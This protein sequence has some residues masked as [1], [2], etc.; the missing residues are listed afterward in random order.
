MPTPQEFITNAL[1][2]A[3]LLIGGKSDTPKAR[4]QVLVS[5]MQESDLTKRVQT[6]G[7]PAHGL[8]QFEGGPMSGIAQC[9]LHAGAQTAAVCRAR[10]VEPTRP[11]I[12]AALVTDDVLAAALAR[13]LLMTDA[14]PLPEIGDEEGAWKTY[15]HNWHPGAPDRQR[16]ARNYPRA[17][18]V[19][20]I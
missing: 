7:G 20:G 17:R 8:G 6:G 16:F 10:G 9:L 19:L 15:V 12:Y 4:L 13:I 2:P 1:E 14:N 3:L 5:C 11:A 18:K